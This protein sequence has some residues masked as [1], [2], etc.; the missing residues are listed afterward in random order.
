M[1]ICFTNAKVDITPGKVTVRDLAREVEA[2]GYK[3]PHI[4]EGPGI[5]KEK[6][7]REEEVKNLKQKFLAG[8][9]RITRTIFSPK[10]DSI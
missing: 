2:L 9:N 4:E 10:P 8:L 6:L 5:D 3:V 1:S 7:A